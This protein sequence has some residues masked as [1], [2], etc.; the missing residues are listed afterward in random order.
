MNTGI[1]V[2]SLL[3]LV[4][5]VLYGAFF[6][7]AVISV[8][9]V[10]F[11][12]LLHI[13]FIAFVCLTYDLFYPHMLMAFSSRDSAP[14][15]EMS[16]W[17]MQINRMHE[18][19]DLDSLLRFVESVLPRL[20][21][22]KAPVILLDAEAG[23]AAVDSLPGM[24]QWQARGAPTAKEGGEDSAVLESDNP[25]L[26][27]ARSRREVIF[28]E[29]CPAA[30]AA[31][32]ARIPASLALPGHGEQRLLC[33][34][35]I[36]L[37]SSRAVF[38]ARNIS[39]L[40]FFYGQ[41]QIALERIDNLRRLQSRKEA[42]Y[43]EKMSLMSTLSATIAHEMR[44]PLSGVRASICGVESYLPD[45]V[46]AY[47]HAS[48]GAPERF[49]PLRADRLATLEHTPAR[50]KSMVDQANAVIDLLLVNLRDRQLDPDTFVV[51]S[52]ADCVDEAMRTYPF[53]RNEQEKIRYHVGQD[54]RFLGIQPMMIYVLFNLLKNA[55]YSVEAA[56]KGSVLLALETGAGENRLTVTDTGLGID[57]AVLPRIF[58]GFFTT[59]TDGTGAGLAFCR[60]TLRN[61]GGDINV[62]SEHGKFTT[63]TLTF[64]PYKRGM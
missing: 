61:F 20:L 13:V 62:M 52:I 57:A 30:V 60:R 36:E 64:P 44:T 40:T 31:E 37:G 4:Y 28:A 8:D 41:L 56:G 2:K 17:V 10:L 42:V 59:K 47:A 39:L 45:L 23:S 51:C 58:E 38:G 49:P 27:Y 3:I 7:L 48:A 50:I 5:T 63:F 43:R 14:A 16:E 24:W 32:L 18:Q 33:L 21:H 22:T 46:A 53:K 19:S 29:E 1:L 34:F 55:L 9:D 15:L 26:Q 6:F 11:Q 12:T 25:L 35:L 54:F